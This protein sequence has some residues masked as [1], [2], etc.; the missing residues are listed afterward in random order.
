MATE[1]GEGSVQDKLKAVAAQ[2]AAGT[3][4]T[5]TLQSVFNN[6][7]ATG[8]PTDE[9]AAYARLKKLEDAMQKAVEET[10]TGKVLQHPSSAEKYIPEKEPDD[11]TPND[12]E[13]KKGGLIR[14]DTRRGSN[15]T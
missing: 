7:K 13:T 4:T 10:H 12:G 9:I 1:K 8:T 2:I 11:E 3:I 15:K 6:P 5:E 14:L